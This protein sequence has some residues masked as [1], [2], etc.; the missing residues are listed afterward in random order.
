MEESYRLAHQRAH[1]GVL[2]L[3]DDGH[4]LYMNVQAKEILEAIAPTKR[5]SRATPLQNLPPVVV[6]LYQQLKKLLRGKTLPLEPLPSEWYTH[7]QTRYLFRSVL[8]HAS[9]GDGP[10]PRL[11]ILIEKISQESGTRRLIQAENLTRREQE[12]AQLLTEGK[13]NKQIA[14]ALGI[15]EFTVKD[16]IKKMMVKLKT[17]TRA[18]IVSKIFNP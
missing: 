5:R 12:V 16:H 3:G 17:N 9:G 2:I 18:G 10:F 15:S 13:I 8:L 1:P 6:S 11:L 4:S 14:M 7:E